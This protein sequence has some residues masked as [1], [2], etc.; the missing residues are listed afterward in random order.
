MAKQKSV[1]ERIHKRCRR[2]EA[3][4]R[5]IASA[6]IQFVITFKFTGDI[7][8]ILTRGDSKYGFKLSDCCYINVKE[9][10]NTEHNEL[11]LMAYSYQISYELPDEDK[12]KWLVRYDYKYSSEIGHHLNAPLQD[13]FHGKLHFPTW[14]DDPDDFDDIEIISD[15]VEKVIPTVNNLLYKH[16]M[17]N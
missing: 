17:K 8:E 11:I 9:Y 16:I 14:P 13:P 1:K 12:P 4:L 5:E 15:I 2:I 3:R 10:F 6:N 7:A